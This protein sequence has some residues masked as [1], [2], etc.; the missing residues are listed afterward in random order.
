MDRGGVVHSLAALVHRETHASTDF[1]SSGNRRKLPE[2]RANAFAAAFLLPRTG[3][4]AFLNA[5]FTV[6]G[7]H[8]DVA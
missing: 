6:L 8:G 4:W 3:V 7:P 2:V 5:R 1:L